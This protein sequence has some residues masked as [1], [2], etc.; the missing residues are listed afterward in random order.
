[1][2]STST[3]PLLSSTANIE[4]NIR[5]HTRPIVFTFPSGFYAR[6]LPG[7]ANKIYRLY[8]YIS[9][10]ICRPH[11]STQRPWYLHSTQTACCVCVY[12]KTDGFGVNFHVCKCLYVQPFLFFLLLFPI[13]ITHRF[14]VGFHI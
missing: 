2:A 12:I 14:I 3:S 4:E 13:V 7:P 1:L 8:S 5:S 9:K 10:S 6:L 11:S